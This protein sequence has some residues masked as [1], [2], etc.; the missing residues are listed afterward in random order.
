VSAVSRN[1]A[2]HYARALFRVT[3]EKGGDESAR[4]RVELG[5]FVSL[6][7]ESSDL[8]SAVE[9][10]AVVPEA[11]GR[12][13]R[14]VSEGAGGSLLLGRLLG[15]LA[16]RGHV[17]LLPALSEFFARLVNAAEGVVAAQVTGAIALTA[18]Q[19]KGLAQALQKSTS[20]QVEMTARVDPRVLG[21]LQVTVGGKTYDGTVRAQLGA[22]RRRLASGI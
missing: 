13:L 5:D 21:G 2:R 20:A 7:E 11:R 12:A 18:D 1:Q 22:L 14:A 17:A 9:H 15:L 19:E 16:E 10:P 8:R 3:E 4:L 6:L